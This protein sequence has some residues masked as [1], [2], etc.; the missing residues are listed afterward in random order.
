M[1]PLEA[2]GFGDLNRGLGTEIETLH[3]RLDELGV[4]METRETGVLAASS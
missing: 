3:H 2:A 1:Q 4:G